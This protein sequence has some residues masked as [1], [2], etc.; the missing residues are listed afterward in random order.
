MATLGFTLGEMISLPVANSYMAELA[1]DDMRDR[2][3]GLLGVSWSLAMMIAPAGG[4][5][6]YQIS[7][8]ALWTSCLTLG[9]TAAWIT[10]KLSKLE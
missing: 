9:L 8:T 7:P 10:S 3:M 4:I 2:F 6:L 1:P 5:F